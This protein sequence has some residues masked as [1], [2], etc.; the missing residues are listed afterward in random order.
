MNAEIRFPSHAELQEIRRQAALLRA[1][2]LR[3]MFSWIVG[4]FSR[5]DDGLP[6]TAESR[7]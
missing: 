3:A 7:A 1:E 5:S 6:A 2:H 4:F